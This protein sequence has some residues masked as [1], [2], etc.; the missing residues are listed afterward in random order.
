MPIDGTRFAIERQKLCMWL[1]GEKKKIEGLSLDERM[2]KD[3]ELEREFRAKID[4]LYSDVHQPDLK[5][6]ALN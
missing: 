5:R 6:Q 1:E 2:R 3:A 4:R